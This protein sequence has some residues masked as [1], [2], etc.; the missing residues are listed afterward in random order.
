M[1]EPMIIVKIDIMIIM[2]IS[3]TYMYVDFIQQ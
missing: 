3:Y 2:M 1:Y